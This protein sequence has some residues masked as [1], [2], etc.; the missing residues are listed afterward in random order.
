MANKFE[1]FKETFKNMSD[2]KRLRNAVTVLQPA[3][4]LGKKLEEAFN[5]LE[6]WFKEQGYIFDLEYSNVEALTKEFDYGRATGIA[7]AADAKKGE[8]ITVGRFMY[9]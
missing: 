5:I 4:Y 8:S 2:T 3:E 7:L 9:T 1:E 6:D